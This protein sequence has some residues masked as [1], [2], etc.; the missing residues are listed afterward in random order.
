MNKK[1]LYLLLAVA[2]TSYRADFIHF[3]GT[4]R[5]L[6]DTSRP[7]IIVAKDHQARNMENRVGAIHLSSGLLNDYYFQDSAGR[8]GYLYVETRVDDVRRDSANRPP[9]NLSIVLDRSGSMGEDREEKKPY[10][11]IEFAKKAAKMIVDRLTAADAISIVVYDNFIN[12]IQKATPDT[13]KVSIKTKLD[14]VNPRGAT[15]LWGGT[16]AGYK[17]MRTFYD[18]G[19][20]NRVLLLSDGEAN[21]GVTDPDVI[22]RKVRAYL[23]S[24]YS[25]STFGVGL[26]YNERLMTQMAINGSGNYYFIDSA[27]RTTALFEQEWRSMV[28]IVAQNA[29]LSITIPNGVKVEATYPVSFQQKG[30]RL[31]IRLQDLSARDVQGILIKFSIQDKFAAPL[32][33][34]TTFKYVETGTRSAMTI[35]NENLLK[36]VRDKNLYL[37]HF[38]RS[39]IEKALLFYADDN[40]ET[41]MNMV[42]RGDL[43]SAKYLLDRNL[44][45]FSSNGAYFTTARD[46][47]TIGTL[48]TEYGQHL[49]AIRNQNKDSIQLLQKKSRAALYR[50]INKKS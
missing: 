30:D 35:V 10:S 2:L 32:D 49:F 50:L 19:K 8:T 27:A 12:V 29:T 3:A 15:D 25:I 47:K 39:V 18:P 14:R 28:Q 48:N 7:P 4:G 38:N 23:D 45:F 20:I 36:P 1:L 13:G 33:F 34:V 41:A 46:L 42:D 22:C 5:Y 21:V 43:A 26:D 11:K 16:E 24:G 44:R 37:S 6:T 40:L 17:E 9:L 31:D